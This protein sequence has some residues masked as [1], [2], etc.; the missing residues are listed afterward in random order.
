MSVTSTLSPPSSFPNSS[1]GTHC[2]AKLRFARR[3]CLRVGN[4]RSNQEGGVFA[5]FTRRASGEFLALWSIPSHP[6]QS[7]A[8]QCVTKL[9]FRH[10]EGQ[11]GD[12]LRGASR[13]RAGLWSR[14]GWASRP[15]QPASRRL[16]RTSFAGVRETR[17]CRESPTL[18]ARPAGR[19]ARQGGRDAH[20]TRDHSDST[21][22]GESARSLGPKGPR[23]LAGGVS[24][25][26]RRL[27][28]CAPAGARENLA[29]TLSR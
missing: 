28:A 22:G 2:G 3:G 6:K 16:D 20:P 27:T 19:D 15:P 10:E 18:D 11:G 29:T 21:V 13:A 26:N 25:R 23:R 7:F 12:A 14:V 24:H 4:A 8:R 5:A 9:E 17:L 1:L